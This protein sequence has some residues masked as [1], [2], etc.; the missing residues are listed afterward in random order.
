MQY[1]ELKAILWHQGCG[2]ARKYDVY[3]G[4]LIK[5][6]TSLRE[7][8]EADVP[9]VAGEL[10]HWRPHTANFNDMIHNIS[11]NIPNSD[12]VSSKGCLPIATKRSDGKPDFKDPHF[13]RKSQILLGKR[14]AD[15]VFKMCYRK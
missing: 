5:F 6:V 10:G 2:D 14:Y 7:E 9:F 8:L 4:K 12:W 15:K 1:G 13:D 11:D 3:M